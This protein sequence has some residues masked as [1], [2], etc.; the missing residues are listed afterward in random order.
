MKIAF[1]TLGCPDWTLDQIL[2]CAEDNGYE[3][4]ELRGLQRELFLPKAPALA[5]SERAGVRRRFE[6]IG[7]PIVCVSSSAKFTSTEQAERDK[8]VDEV[9]AFATLGAD[10]GAR[11]IRVFGGTLEPGQT[12]EE[13]LPTMAEAGRRAAE[14]AQE[15]GL[16]VVIETHDAFCR[17]R[18]LAR[19]VEAVAHEAF[20]SLWDI[21]HP[22]AHGE[23]V[24]E[25]M[26][27]LGPSLRH[28]HTKDARTVEGKRAYCLFGEG[29]LP[30]AEILRAL[31]AHGYGGWLSLEWEKMW[32]P[33]IAEPE[34]ALP[35]YARTMRRLLS[36]VG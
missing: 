26:A 2:A 35:H 17:G 30:I 9:R 15:A 11:L 8:N 31:K 3:G 19:V 1:S 33:E 21:H 36:E 28:V 4:L 20:Q 29:E 34:V 23:S 24:T 16:T 10:L 13:L 18:D 32:H 5:P 27:A 6:D 7:C 12:I 14:A 22:L 25:T